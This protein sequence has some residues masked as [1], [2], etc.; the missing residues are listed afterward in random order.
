[1]SYRA[2]HVESYTQNVLDA[3]QAFTECRVGWGDPPDQILT[4]LACIARD[5]A[6]RAGLEPKSEGSL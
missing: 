2:I 6:R 4:S 5:A 3:V 1:M